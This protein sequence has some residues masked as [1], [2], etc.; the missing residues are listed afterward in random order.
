M[1]VASQA[2]QQARFTVY[3]TNSGYEAH[4]TNSAGGRIFK[5]WETLDELKAALEGFV[6]A[7][8]PIRTANT[9]REQGAQ[10]K[11]E[12]YFDGVLTTA[13]GKAWQV[14]ISALAAGAMFFGMDK[15]IS[16]RRLADFD[17][18]AEVANAPIESEMPA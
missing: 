12:T 13:K 2:T 7:D 10:P 17:L 3:V 15:R 11:F 8:K 14:S 6:L 5:L 9:N 4:G 16:N 18:D 1:A